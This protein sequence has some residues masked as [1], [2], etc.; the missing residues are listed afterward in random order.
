MKKSKSWLA[1][2]CAGLA[3]VLFTLSGNIFAYSQESEPNT[4]TDLGEVKAINAEFNFDAVTKGTYVKLSD[5]AEAYQDIIRELSN[6]IPDFDMS[7]YRAFANEY[8]DGKGTVKLRYY[9]GDI[10]T[11]AV[12]TIVV[13]DGK[14]EYMSSEYSAAHYGKVNE[15]III[16]KN[17]NRK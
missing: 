2:A 17:W 1:A 11:S 3:V 4:D 10:Q 9:I 16:E 7:D 13:E 14:A 6:D 8:A 5:E 15:D 12:L